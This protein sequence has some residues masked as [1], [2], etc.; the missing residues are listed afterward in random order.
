MLFAPGPEVAATSDTDISPSIPGGW[1]ELLAQRLAALKGNHANGYSGLITPYGKKAPL[2]SC[3]VGVSGFS[4]VDSDPDDYPQWAWA[5]R[6][7]GFDVAARLPVGVIGLDV[8]HGYPDKRGRI[9]RG[10]DT[11]A[12]LEAKWGPLPPTYRVTAR[13][14]ETGSGIRLYRVDA[15]RWVWPGDSDPADIEIIDHNHRFVRP[16]AFLG[17]EGRRVAHRIAG[18]GWFA[19]RRRN[20]T[21][22][23]V[24]LHAATKP[25]R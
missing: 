17:T 10:L 12:E 24:A 1:R 13:P 4:P 11:L 7:H 3:C 6:F 5:N 22:G 25:L 8:D 23:I 19:V 21:G 15:G 2:L 14:Y 9:K 18:A 20:L 16:T